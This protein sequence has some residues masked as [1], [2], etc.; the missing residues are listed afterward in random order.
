MSNTEVADATL[1]R[2]IFKDEDAGKTR[3]GLPYRV[4]ADDRKG[5]FPLVVLVETIP[6]AE[7]L[8][9]YTKFGRFL[10]ETDHCRDLMP[11]SRTVFVNFHPGNRAYYFP[12]KEAAVRAASC[13]A[14]TVIT[15]I[16]IELPGA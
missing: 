4:I 15:A 14:S 2:Y 7:Y 6:G 12:S 1:H 11:P 8:S 5:S 13:A 3:D 9:S 10:G 16:P